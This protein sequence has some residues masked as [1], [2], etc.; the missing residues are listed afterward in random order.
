[1]MQCFFTFKKVCVFKL[2]CLAASISEIA[3][4]FSL[5]GL[6]RPSSSGHKSSQ[7]RGQ[8]RFA[9]P[10]YAFQS[11]AGASAF[12]TQKI[13]QTFFWLLLRHLRHFLLAVSAVFV[14]AVWVPVRL[15][16]DYREPHRCQ[17]DHRTHHPYKHIG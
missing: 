14:F 7:L 13:Y 5:S 11:L 9:D 10:P 2:S 6:Q 17:Y 12:P 3:C 16:E 15:F 4:R 8:S 1:M